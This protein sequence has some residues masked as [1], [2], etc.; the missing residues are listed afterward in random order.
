M[1][2]DGYP[3]DSPAAVAHLELLRREGTTHLLVPEAAFWWLAHYDGFARHLEQRY[4]A[5]WRDRHCV[6]YDLTQG[7]T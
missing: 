6:I 7:A 5:L 4:L 3:A 2:Q 1:L